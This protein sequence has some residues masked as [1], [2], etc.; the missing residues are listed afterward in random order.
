MTTDVLNLLNHALTLPDSDRAEIAV[1]LLESLDGPVEQGV[2]EAWNR[3][4]AQRLAQIDAGEVELVSWDL[5]TKK[6]FGSMDA[7]R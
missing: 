2:E 4:I 7:P 5:A 3:E 6:I 1:R